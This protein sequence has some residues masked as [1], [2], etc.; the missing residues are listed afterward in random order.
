[1]L[2]IDTI[3]IIEPEK[4]KANWEERKRILIK[5][6]KVY[7][8]LKELINLAKTPPYRSLAIFKTT[9]IIDFYS[10]PTER[11]WPQN[12][13]EQIQERCSRRFSG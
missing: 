2:N 1:V 9:K 13:L 6:E 4:T 10:E 12:K 11:E 7:T 3:K 8:N 5:S